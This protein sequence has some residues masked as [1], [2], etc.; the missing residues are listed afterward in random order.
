M[1]MRFI[2]FSFFVRYTSSTVIGRHIIVVSFSGRAPVEFYC[3]V[4]ELHRG[5]LKPKWQLPRWNAVG[6]L[7]RGDGSGVYSGGT[8]HALV[9]A[10]T[11][12][13]LGAL[14][15]TVCWRV[16]SRGPW[17]H[18]GRFGLCSWYAAPTLASSVVRWCAGGSPPL[19]TCP[20]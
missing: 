6:G 3:R 1:N 19:L 13:R 5:L 18:M 14:C 20:Y 16:S 17:I 2:H 10:T 12:L 9:L 7:A 15:A 11:A 8:R 4:A